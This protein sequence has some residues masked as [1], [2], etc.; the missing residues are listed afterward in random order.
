[1]KQS[2]D[3]IRWWRVLLLIPIA[4]IAGVSIV[5]TS[6]GSGSGD[7]D[8]DNGTELPPT[9][10]SPMNFLLTSLPGDVP[11]TVS[12]GGDLTV[13]VDF[14]DI[15]FG[16]VDLTVSADNSV[17]FD[18]F[19]TRDTLGL[20]ITVSG[21]GSPLDGTFSFIVI[22]T[23]NT[24][25]GEDPNSG[26]FDVVTLTETVTVR[27]FSPGVEISLFAGPTIPYD[28]WDDFTGALDDELKDTWE[29][30]ASLAGGVYELIYE[31]ALGVA[32]SLD[33]LQTVVLTNPIV[34]SCDMFTGAPPAEVVADPG[35]TT[36][37]WLGSDEVKPGD[38]FDWRFTDCWSDDP[39]DDT[40]ELIR[41]GIKLEN[42]AETIDSTTN[43]LFEVGFGSLGNGPG[44]VI[45]D[46]LKISETQEDMDGDFTI[47]PED[48]LIV[49]GGFV[50]I[51]QQF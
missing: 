35:E 49:N 39:S 5:A 31:L 13:E 7:G 1:M 16:S 29:R 12:A 33:E 15:V 4:V 2:V 9:I 36:I 43:T 42:Y 27:I 38:N 18:S 28:T 45:F 11:L 25:I 19:S 48:D 37:T 6:G 8:S 17:T 34:E 41:G 23:I 10:P 50:L 26:I 40:D 44:G 14:T 47:D 32:D 24:N 22:E 3:R 46:N 51:F 30:R 21:S 20:E